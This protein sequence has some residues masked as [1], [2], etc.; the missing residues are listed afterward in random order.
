MTLGSVLQPLQRRRSEQTKGFPD[1][2]TLQLVRESLDKKTKIILTILILSKPLMY[3]TRVSLFMENCVT[4]LMMWLH[5]AEAMTH[6]NA[7]VA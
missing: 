7:T 4:K 1:H 6:I 3:F 5:T 2:I